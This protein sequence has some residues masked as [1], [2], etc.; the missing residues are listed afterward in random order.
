[1][2]CAISF[3]SRTLEGVGFQLCLVLPP[4]VGAAGETIKSFK[5][6]GKSD[7]K[8]TNLVW[9]QRK[10]MPKVPSMICLKPCL[11][12]HFPVEQRGG[13]ATCMKEDT[14]EIVWQERVGGNFSASPVTAGGRIYFLSDE[15]VTTVIA[16][17]PQFQVLARNPLEEKIQASIAVSQEHLFIRTATHLYCFGKKIGI[18]TPAGTALGTAESRRS[19][20]GC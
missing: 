14:G 5:T 15:G 12:C 4:A 1:M 13:I 16:A 3:G 17:G 9:E 19:A 10:G 18:P 6:G 7:L 11:R 20:T 8:E 2:R